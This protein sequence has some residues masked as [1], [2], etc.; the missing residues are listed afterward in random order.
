VDSI[1]EKKMLSTLEIKKYGNTILTELHCPT[2]GAQFF[3]LAG[4][5]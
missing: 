2:L 5:G 1:L 3:S 4:S